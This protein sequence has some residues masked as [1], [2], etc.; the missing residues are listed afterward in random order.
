METH[1][2]EYWLE[3]I[4]R[5]KVD[6]DAEAILKQFFNEPENLNLELRTKAN[7]TRVVYYLLRMTGKPL[8]EI[9]LEDV[10]KYF[11]RR[12]EKVKPTTLESEFNLIRR[13][14]R[15]I[16]IELNS[17]L[18]PSRKRKF[19][20]DTSQFLTDSEFERL[21]SVLKHSRDKALIMLLRETG[22]R[23]GEALALDVRDVEITEHYGRLHVRYSKTAERYVEFVKSI[24]YLRAW[25]SIHPDPRP[26]SPLF[27]KLRGKLE[28]LTYQAVWKLLRD[29]LKRAGIDKK[30]HPHL[31][32]HQ[33]AT[34][35]L[36]VEGLPEEAVRIYM[37]WKHGSRMISRYSH[38][39][40]EK[41][42]ELV[43]KARY[44]IKTR[45]EREEP[46]GYRECPRCGRMV[47][48]KYKYCPYCGL[49]LDRTTAIEEARARNEV[50]ELLRRLVEDPSLREKLKA[51]L[52]EL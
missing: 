25:L 13:F 21:L 45:E 32:R 14:L 38:V 44:G 15:Y 26:D 9:G 37:G 39:S 31:F 18:K 30:V 43:M 23:I 3:K 10:K 29:A 41:A 2:P 17:K 8:R 48:L 20:V 6:P 40:S 28:R 42:N 7:Y 16:G 4:R 27:V 24:P 49:A 19:V 35:L 34:E 12:A 11:V 5:L 33:V 50:R 52:Q 46:K 22:L 51:I 36:S 47:E 1:T